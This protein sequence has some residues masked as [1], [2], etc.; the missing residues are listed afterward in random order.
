[1]DTFQFILRKLKI[2]NYEEFI[3]ITRKKI[4]SVVDLRKKGIFLKTT[5]IVE[6][7]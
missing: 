7:D 2:Q 4:E 6:L 1:M 5:N 3:Q